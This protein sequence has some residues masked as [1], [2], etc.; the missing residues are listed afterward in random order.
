MLTQW[1]VTRIVV[2]AT[3]ST[4]CLTPNTAKGQNAEEVLRA[5][6]L[7][8][9]LVVHLGV[10]DGQLELDLAKGG[11]LLV[12]GL[13]EDEASQNKVRRK[14]TEAGVY[15]VASVELWSPQPK[16]PYAA[17][18]VNVLIADK[19]LLARRGIEPAEVLRVLVPGGM[20]YLKDG[21]AWK[22]TTKPWP[23]RPNSQRLR[24]LRQ[25]SIRTRRWPWRSRSRRKRKY[26]PR[27]SSRLRRSVW[28]C[29]PGALARLN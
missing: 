12:H 15:G 5:A 22:A 13:S 27:W 11:R 21:D 14:L 6:R 3:V 24:S 7:T 29:C 28:T 18:L 2:L 19:A 4:F 9:G 20:A 25:S 16:L 17:D 23:G 8:A 10:S 1:I 26:P